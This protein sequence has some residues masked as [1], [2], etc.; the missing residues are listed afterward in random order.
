MNTAFRPRQVYAGGH[1]RP[2]HTS[3]YFQTTCAKK[4]KLM[5]RRHRGRHSIRR[6]GLTAT[7]RQVNIACKRGRKQGVYYSGENN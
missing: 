1:N 4:D 6:Q 3:R 7:Y 2:G 5:L